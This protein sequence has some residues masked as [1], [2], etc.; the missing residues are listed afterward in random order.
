MITFRRGNIMNTDADYVVVPV[1]CVGK[2]GRGLAKQWSEQA[3][4]ISLRTYINACNNG[5]LQ[6]GGILFFEESSFILAA[7]KNHW[8]YASE[9]VWIDEILIRLN[10]LS[11]QRKWW[12]ENEK[13]VAL[14]KLG[15]GLGRLDWRIVREMMIEHLEQLPTLFIA[16]E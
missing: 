8:L 7:T 15:C 14:P 5:S 11:I 2:P 12:R 1:N 4:D 10:A 13:S 16:Y 9:Y 3:P 6:P